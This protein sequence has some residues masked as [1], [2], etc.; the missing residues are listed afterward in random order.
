MPRGRGVSDRQRPHGNAAS[1]R[2]RNSC[3][4]SVD[5]RSHVTS[6]PPGPAPSGLAPPPRAGRWRLFGFEAS[7]LMTAPRRCLPHLIRPFSSTFQDFPG[8]VPKHLP[9][10]EGCGI[11]GPVWLQD[12]AQRKTPLAQRLTR[13][14]SGRDQG[15]DLAPERNTR[16]CCVQGPGNSPREIRSVHFLVQFGST[17]GSDRREPVGIVSDTLARS[18]RSGGC[19]R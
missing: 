2:L 10:Q 15:G 7:V 8:H 14:S 19:C 12:L 3:R 16:W 11:P 9:P 17:Q 1:F 5:S 18:C 4:S 6:P 13:C